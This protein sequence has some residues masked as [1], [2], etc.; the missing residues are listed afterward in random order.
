MAY[1]GPRQHFG[2]DGQESRSV[3]ATALDHVDL[4][5]IENEGL[6]ELM[7]SFPEDR[8]KVDL[9]PDGWRRP[10]PARPAT[11]IDVPVRRF[12]RA[13][14]WMRGHLWLGSLSFPLLLLHSGFSAKGSLTSWL[15]ALLIITIGTGLLGAIVQHYLPRLMTRLVPMETIYEE[16]PRVREQL[17]READELMASLPRAGT[18]DFAWGARPA[19]SGRVAEAE[20]DSEVLDHLREVY[21][22]TIRPFLSDSDMVKNACSDQQRSAS[23]FSSL[24]LYAPAPAHKILSGLES[25]CEEERQLK[26][27]RQ[28]YRCLHVWLLVHVPLSLALIL[29]GAIHAVVALGY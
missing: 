3:T 9:T 29:L 17:E 6:H 28:L 22:D 7:A 5:R 26:R 20:I 25:I 11:K 12:G 1:L 16:I 18:R 21:V 14:T 15:M 4:I 2:L 27:Q 8:E 13:S 19:K 23:L 10:V 24:R